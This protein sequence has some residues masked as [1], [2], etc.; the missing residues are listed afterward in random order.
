MK[1]LLIILC[2][3][4][5]SR[6]WKKNLRKSRDAAQWA[7][8]IVV[9]PNDAHGS[10]SDKFQRTTHIRTEYRIQMPCSVSILSI[11]IKLEIVFGFTFTIVKK[12]IQKKLYY[13]WLFVDRFFFVDFFEWFLFSALRILWLCSSA[14]IPLRCKSCINFHT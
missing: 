4:F 12:S 8:L 3:F 13:G 9:P 1:R 2:S 11:P 14:F 10:H 7:E 5:A 6:K